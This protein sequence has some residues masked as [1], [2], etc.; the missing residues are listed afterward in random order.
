MTM[1]VLEAPGTS[2]GGVAPAR[3]K[4]HPVSCCRPARGRA[5]GPPPAI[6]TS[7]GASRGSGQGLRLSC[8]SSFAGR[9]CGGAFTAG[10]LLRQETCSCSRETLFTRISRRWLQPAAAQR[11]DLLELSL[12][13]ICEGRPQPCSGQRASALTR[14]FASRSELPNPH[15]GPVGSCARHCVPNVLRRLAA[16]QESLSRPLRA[17]VGSAPAPLAI[18]C[19]VLPV[20]TGLAGLTPLLVALGVHCRLSRLSCR[21][22][23]C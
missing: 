20:E 14:V 17:L 5:R 11:Q 3:D 22:N 8:K 9:S 21:L 12:V 2:G 10:A 6:R 23:H 16:R 15:A 13:C 4:W 1:Q 18:Y 7:E 19:S